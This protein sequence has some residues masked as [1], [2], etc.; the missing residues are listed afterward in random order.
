MTAAIQ[1]ATRR[2][3]LAAPDSFKAEVYWTSRHSAE[4]G[5]LFEKIRARHGGK[6]TAKDIVH[7]AEKSPILRPYF[8]WDYTKAAIRYRLMQARRLLVRLHVRS[9]TDLGPIRAYVAVR[10]HA[11]N[12]RKLMYLPLTSALQTEHY[13]KEIIGRMRARAKAYEA[14]IGTVRAYANAAD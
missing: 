6:L 13:R 4:I 7:A 12:P 3:D 2:Q 11:D 8:E 14:S 1:P 5:N 9:S 10:V